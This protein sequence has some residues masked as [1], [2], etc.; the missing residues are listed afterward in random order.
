[1]QELVEK[2]QII[3]KEN[4]SKMQFTAKRNKTGELQK[5]VLVL[6]PN[7]WQLQKYTEKQVFHETMSVEKLEETAVLLL[8]DDFTQMQAFSEE[9]IYSVRVTAKGKVLFNRKAQSEPMKNIGAQTSHNRKKNYILPEG[10]VVEPL[11]DMGIFTTE[12][13]VIQSMYDKY[14]QINRFV[15]LVDD[16]LKHEQGKTLHIID[17][18]CGKSYLTFILYYYFTEIKKIEVC[19]TGLDLKADVVEKCNAAAKKY[20]YN[21]LHFEVG[22]IEG[23]IPK[24]KP[25]MVIS[26]HA[27]DTATDFA[28]YHGIQWNAKY[29]FSVPC[30]QHELNAQMQTEDLPIFTRYGLVQERVSALMTDAIRANLLQACGY[31]TQLVEF[32]GFEHTPKN[33]LIRGVKSNIP[34]A[35][36]QKMMQEVDSFNQTFA[37]KPTFLSLLAPTLVEQKLY[38]AVGEKEEPEKTS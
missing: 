24:E 20:G 30:C 16:A 31:K 33:I 25:D 10:E 3:I 5:A 23:Y 22:N 1:M 14:K 21:N 32:V 18:G 6:L 4:T 37:T 19:M 11:V 2:I 26:L 12:G 15:E 36:K 17:F 35:H 28:L 29:I 27:C 38:S 8:E 13:K 7:G 9:F 34:F